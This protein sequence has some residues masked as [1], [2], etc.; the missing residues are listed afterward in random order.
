MILITISKYPQR[1]KRQPGLLVFGR[2]TKFLNPLLTLKN[3]SVLSNIVGSF[4]LKD[5]KLKKYE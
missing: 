1:M 5:G 4:I 3:L 2:T